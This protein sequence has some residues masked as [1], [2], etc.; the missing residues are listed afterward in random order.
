MTPRRV[1]GSQAGSSE[2]LMRVAWGDG[3]G[4]STGAAARLLTGVI[5]RI[6][7]AALILPAKVEK[8]NRKRM[9]GQGNPCGAVAPRYA[10]GRVLRA[11]R[12]L[13]PEGSKTRP[14]A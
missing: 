11:L 14:R 1:K 4:A 10:R 5:A 3:F 8:S 6:R 7:R 9:G 2:P 12:V 13:H